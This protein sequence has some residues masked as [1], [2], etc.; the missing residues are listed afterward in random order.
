MESSI[1]SSTFSEDQFVSVLLCWRGLIG[2]RWEPSAK[3][4]F[5]KSTASD[6]VTNL[7]NTH[8]PCPGEPPNQIRPPEARLHCMRTFCFIKH[9]YLLLTI[10]LKSLEL[11][12]TKTIYYLFWSGLIWYII[13]GRSKTT[14]LFSIIL[15]EQQLYRPISLFVCLFFCLVVC[16]SVYSYMP[17]KQ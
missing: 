14:E 11:T 15:V 17:I 3:L 8:C 13:S 16:L 6:F 7:L 2:V 4:C 12:K 1:K 5:W 10:L 9:L